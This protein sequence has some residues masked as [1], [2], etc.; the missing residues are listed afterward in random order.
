MASGG[1]HP[2]HA[3]W[4]SGAGNNCVGAIV[5]SLENLEQT[6]NRIGLHVSISPEL[7]S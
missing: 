4:N 7:S 5:I 3:N 6:G 1:F 2:I